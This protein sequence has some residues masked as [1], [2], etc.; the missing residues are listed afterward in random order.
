MKRIGEK[1]SRF[2]KNK[3]INDF[4]TVKP[5]KETLFSLES[6][7][8]IYKVLFFV[9]LVYLIILFLSFARFS[10]FAVSTVSSFG[11]DVG[12]NVLYFEFKDGLSTTDFIHMTDQQLENVSNMT[13]EVSGSGKIEF[14][15]H[16]NL[17]LDSINDVIDLDS[18]I[19]ISNA[20]INYDGNALTS[21]SEK[22]AR[23][24]FNGITFFN[25]RLRKDG[26]LCTL[27]CELVSYGGGTYIT[28]VNYSGNYVLEETPYCGD[29]TCNSNEGETCGSC[30]NDCGF[31]PD[32]T[33]PVITTPSTSAPASG[34]GGGGGAAFV[35]SVS[36]IFVKSSLL[37]DKE[38]IK[39]SLK[40]G[41]SST[42]YVYISN[43]ALNDIFVNLTSS[44]LD[45]FL[46]IPEPGLTIKSKQS[47]KVR[48][49]FNVK[50]TENPDSYFGKINLK[51][52]D[53]SKNTISVILD[54]KE[55]KPLFDIKTKVQRK[56]ILPGTKIKANI[57]LINMGDFSNVDVVL[58]Y[59]IKDME[60]K[61]LS[62]SQESLAV[63]KRLSVTREL[64]IPIYNEG[65]Y[66]FY[67]TVTYAN[68]TA[69]SSDHFK[70]ALQ[71]EFPI[72]L[73][74]PRLISLVIGLILFILF[75]IIYRYIR[76]RM[77][78]YV[79]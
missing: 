35:S 74:D 55:K 62:F 65:D 16:V 60:G 31:C 32:V 44:S 39:L 42:E 17:A 51:N 27:T 24:T 59:S 67:S 22:S 4:K 15:D 40:Q 68:T 66:I 9:C 77:P 45:N 12:L 46:L 26:S 5:R 61:V 75:Y 36:T 2:K 54:V 48:L 19:N 11:V 34:G 18:N 23:L 70:I 47:V 63:Q 57:D 76:R 38:L 73:N 52:S 79:E 7:Y 33:P 50:E 8:L 56:I 64:E 6:S 29:N 69:I 78:R 21:I 1:N 53:G 3:I 30:V 28:L 58:Y 14:L 10:G 41:E 13:L 71:E 49:D 37:F 72:K 25:P 20:N 43:D